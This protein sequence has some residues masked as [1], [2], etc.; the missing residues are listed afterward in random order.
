MKGLLS[1]FIL[2]P[3][4]LFFRRYTSLAVERRACA[5]AAA[6]RPSFMRLLRLPIVLAILI[7]LGCSPREMVKVTDPAGSPV[8]GAEVEAIPPST[9]T[10]PQVT[11][12]KGE[13]LI[14]SKGTK[15]V[16]VSKPGFERTQVDVPKRWPLRVTLKPTTR[17]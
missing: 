16:A 11:D 10:G 7:S 1:A 12:A 8:A 5:A 2:P 6:Q 9:N 14:P 17:P 4:S 13:A 15:W 3:S